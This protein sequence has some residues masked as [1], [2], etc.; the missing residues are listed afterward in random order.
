MIFS[1]YDTL[2]L[3]FI[4]GFLGW[5]VEVAFVAVNSGKVVNRGFLNGPICPIY[6]VGMVGVL[7]ALTPL[8]DNAFVLFFGAMIICSAIELFGGWALDKLFH[9]R[10]WDYSNQPFNIHGYICLKFSIMWGFGAMVMVKIIHPMI[11]D[12][13]VKIPQIAGI[14]FLVMFSVAMAADMVV[15]LKTVI[16]IKKSLGQLEKLAEGLHDIGD[17]IK[18]VV[19]NS[20]L[21]AAEKAEE[22]KDKASVVVTEGREKMSEVIEEN[23]EKVAAGREKISG[24]YANSREKIADAY[25]N[26][27]EKIADAYENSKEKIADA[28]EESRE[29]RAMDRLVRE[30]ERQRKEL[31]LNSQKQEMEEKYSNMLERLQKLSKRQIKA[32]PTFKISGSTESL[33]DKINSL[34]RK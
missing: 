15:T 6:G 21:A 34:R 30:A 23:K 4:Y 9:M 14:I 8:K 26:S 28:Y 13:F 12:V 27:R 2:A 1:F 24:A 16:G 5:C 7:M 29:K 20:A 19:G 25:E 10:W 22:G 17:Q 32:F 33:K 31:E 18:D 3:F 11:Y